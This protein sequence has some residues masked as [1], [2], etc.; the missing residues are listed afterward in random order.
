MFNKIERKPKCG[1]RKLKVGFVSC[2]LAFGILTSVGSPLI[3]N[4]VVEAKAQTESEKFL[5]AFGMTLKDVASRDES[6]QAKAFLSKIDVNDKKSSFNKD[7]LIRAAK[8]LVEINNFR[9]S[10]GYTPLKT[11][12]RINL[13]SAFR[14][15]YYKTHKEHAEMFNTGEIAWARYQGQATNYE[16]HEWIPAY[17]VWHD[18]EKENFDLVLKLKFGIDKPVTKSEILAAIEKAGGSFKIEVAT[19][20]IPEEKLKYN[21]QIGHFL[22]FVHDYSIQGY[23]FGRWEAPDG[24]GPSEVNVLSYKSRY[25]DDKNDPLVEP[26][27]YFNWLLSIDSKK[28]WSQVSDKWYFV[29]NNGKLAKTEWLYDNNYSSWYYF[30]NNGDMATNKWIKDTNS[31]WYYLSGNGKMAKNEWI[32]DN[33]YSSWYYFN[34]NGDM[35][36]NKWV[37]DTNSKWYYLLGNGKMAK[38]EWFYDNNYSSWYYFNNNGDMATNKWVKDTNGK[39]YYLLGN[40]KMAK[41]TTINGWYVDSNGV[42]EK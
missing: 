6:G 35:A 28:G 29:K 18:D 10:K 4:T 31:K 39:W 2:L 37:K 30:N 9:K 19:G 16:K 5:Q 34:N 27:E 14:N 42:W 33:N 38:N 1:I 11:N 26:E 12:K 25:E 13:E 20:S 40:G 22:A 8:E 15:E 7:N 41:S 36:T 32:Y 24:Y 23:G 21:G 3:G 17:K